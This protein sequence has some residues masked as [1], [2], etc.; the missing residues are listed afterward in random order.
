M[1]PVTV[2]DI[3]VAPPS[4][5]GAQRADVSGSA[6]ADDDKHGNSRLSENRLDLKSI[7]TDTPECNFPGWVGQNTGP[8]EKQPA[9][10]CLESLRLAL[11]VA[12]PGERSVKI[13]IIDGLPDVTHPALQSAS[14]K[15]LDVM[16]PEGC[17]T[18]DPHGT[19]ICSIIF[20]NSDTA[21]GIVPGCSG[22]ILPIFFGSHA[23]LRPRLASQ[24][25]LARAII[26]ALE[27][28]VSIINVSAGQRALTPAADAHLSQALQY[29]AERRVLVVAAA[30]ND[31]CACLHLPAAIDSVLAVGAIDGCGQP[32]ETSNWGEP[33]RQNGILAPGQG[34]TVATLAGGVGMA[35]GTSYAT[36]LVSGVSALLLS[37]SRRHGYRV[38]AVDIQRILIE[39]AAPCTL[40]GDGACDRFLAGTLD[41]AAALASL[42]LLGSARQSA[43]LMP[44]GAGVSPSSAAND[45][46][47]TF[48]RRERTMTEAT[49]PEDAAA[50]DTRGIP[51]GAADDQ[52]QAE[53]RS[54]SGIT[55]SDVV[56]T[57]SPTRASTIIKSQP[58]NLLSQQSCSCGCGQPA[59]IVYVLG[60]LWYDFVTEARRDAFVQ[61]MGPSASADNPADLIAFLRGRP[62]EAMGLAFVLRQEDTAIYAVQ[63]AGPF[64][65]ETY[66]AMFD[67]LTSSLD[68]GGLEQRVSIPGFISGSTRLWNGQTIPVIC[69]DLRGMYKWRSSTLIDAVQAAAAPGVEPAPTA[70]LVDFLNRVYYELRNLGIAPQDRALN[71][72]ATNAY[73]AAHSLADAAS[74]SLVLDSI[75]VVKSPI[76]RPDS[77]CWDVQLVMFDDEDER[78]PNRVYRFT[79]DVSEIIPVTV[80]QVRNW[81]RRAS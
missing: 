59:Q 25:D 12:G 20:G 17:W 3:D 58:S 29:C 32:L 75:N 35:N 48:T 64:A 43:T 50:S 27:H 62:A 30:G 74:R 1:T 21:R 19:A 4:T 37:V 56:P 80:G 61:K 47:H 57:L 18:P 39:S 36:A 26:L 68:S 69:P 55:Q 7:S 6:A 10:N 5:R 72:A 14:I 49:I 13:G 31:G 33:Y 34:L 38:D 11:A 73:Q 66:V 42:H 46:Q 60:A 79:V 76:C 54:K 40:S 23:E 77:D 28:G 22:L 2:H 71:F 16:V 81:P 9:A 78:K 67:A 52:T 15:I 63:P 8:I 70:D 44:L 51:L 45:P 24:L 53:E 65:H 41:A